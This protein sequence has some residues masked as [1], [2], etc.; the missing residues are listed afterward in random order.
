MFVVFNKEKI[1]S[2]LVSLGTVVILFVMAIAI[3]SR[4]EKLIETSTN[5]IIANKIEQNE[6]NIDMESS[7]ENNTNITKMLQK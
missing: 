1:Y 4:N 3:T 7:K 2:Y 5:A 6:Y